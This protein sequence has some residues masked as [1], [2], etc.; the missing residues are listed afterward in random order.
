MPYPPIIELGLLL[1]ELNS[2]EALVRLFC[3]YVAFD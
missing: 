1:R 3:F 2:I